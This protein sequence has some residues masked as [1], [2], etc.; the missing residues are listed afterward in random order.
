MPAT[1]AR[2]ASRLNRSARSRQHSAMTLL[3]SHYVAGKIAEAEWSAI[4]AT[5]DEMGASRAERAAFAA[6][7]LD[8]AAEGEPELPEPIEFEDVLVLTR[9]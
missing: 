3:F 4:S 8:A 5:L 6:F 9:A 1:I 7:C 2:T